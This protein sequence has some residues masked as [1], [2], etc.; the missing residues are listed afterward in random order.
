MPNYPYRC[1]NCHKRFDIFM[2]YSEY[3]SQP[4]FCPHCKSDQ[5]QRRIGRIRVAK[6]EESR[7]ENLAD[8]SSLAGMEEDPKAM[9]QMMRRM[10]NDMGEDL[11]PEFDEVID[12][13]E[14]G[15]NPDDIEKDLPDLGGE[16]SEGYGGMDEDF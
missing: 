14:A 3:G 11:G 8:P 16:G 2:S 9:G 5:V 4:V 15:Q 13:L 6:S 7:M 1:L 12:R 10:S